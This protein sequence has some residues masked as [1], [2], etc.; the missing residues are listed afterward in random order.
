MAKTYMQKGGSSKGKKK[1]VVG[2]KKVVVGRKSKPAGSKAIKIKKTG[3][4][5][6]KTVSRAIKIKSK[7]KS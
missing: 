5:K 7:K 4:T 6:S 1:V 2:S 3:T